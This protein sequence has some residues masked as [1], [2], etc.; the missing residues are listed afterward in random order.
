MWVSGWARNIKI[1][2]KLKTIMLEIN[3]GTSYDELKVHLTDN[4]PRFDT[5]L[6]CKKDSSFKLFG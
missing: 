1:G 3:D 6:A 4:M 2:H 5:L